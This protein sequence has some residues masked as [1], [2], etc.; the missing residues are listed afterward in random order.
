MLLNATHRAPCK[1]APTRG[2][3]ACSAAC[4]TAPR[5]CT[6]ASTCGALCAAQNRGNRDT[7]CTKHKCPLHGPK[8][9]GPRGQSVAHARSARLALVEGKSGDYK[10]CIKGDGKIKDYYLKHPT[11]KVPGEDQ[12]FADANRE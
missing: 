10:E 11:E 2:A 8:R 6:R 9:D 3:G 1:A 12:S 7:K 4:P 5:S